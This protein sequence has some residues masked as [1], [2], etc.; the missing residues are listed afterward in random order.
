LRDF[1]TFLAQT[2]PRPPN[3]IHACRRF[4]RGKVLIT[5][6]QK[7]RQE[8]SIALY[9]AKLMVILTQLFKLARIV[10]GEVHDPKDDIWNISLPRYAWKTVMALLIPAESA[11]R[12]LIVMGTFGK[13]FEP[14]PAE[15]RHERAH[16]KD[17]ADVDANP[18]QAGAQTLADRNE[19][20]GA[21]ASRSPRPPL[22]D[23]FDPLKTFSYIS[24]DSIEEFHTWKAQKDANPLIVGPAD[25]TKRMEPVGALSIWRRIH[26]MHHAME[27]FDDY[28]TRYGRWRAGRKAELKAKGFLNGKHATTL[29][30]NSRPPGYVEKEGDDIHDI[31]RDVHALAYDSELPKW[32]NSS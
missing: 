24:F 14:E 9:K 30:R 25:P 1:W 6:Y 29:M 16:A 10:P 23:M 27:N 32:E 20:P 11:L 7:S 2:Y 13:S 31:L 18:T 19:V 4:E 22:F 21:G 12:R 15:A 3:L 5:D 26:A 17:A 28:V 8:V